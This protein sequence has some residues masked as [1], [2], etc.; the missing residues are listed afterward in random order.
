MDEELQKRISKLSDDELWNMVNAN[1]GDYRKEALDFAEEELQSRCHHQHQA[2]KDAENTILPLSIDDVPYFNKSY[3]GDLIITLGVLY[4][5]PHTDLD[6][7][8]R[9]KLGQIMGL[10]GVLIEA[11][12]DQ[13][14]SVNR[15]RL[16]KNGLWNNEDSS[17]T[18]QK[19]L[20]SYIED[21]KQKQL[22]NTF[23]SSSSLPHLMRFPHDEVKNL[24]MNEFRRSK[25]AGYQKR[26][27]CPSYSCSYPISV[28]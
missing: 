6:K 1:P 13:F 28:P 25:T 24:K 27:S 10:T 23:S 8:T 15:S 12:A 7:D 2:T 4:Y 22:F 19:K 9:L 17:E 16:R 20:D 3:S 21:A 18:L 26:L 5:F 11:V 14:K